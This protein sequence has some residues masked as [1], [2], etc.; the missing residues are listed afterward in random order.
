ME[1]ILTINENNFEPED[2]T[3]RNVVRLVIFNETKDKILFFGNNLVGGGVEEG[4]TDE[5]AIHREA[6][7]EVG[8]TVKIVKPIGEAVAYRDF[9]K[10]KYIVHGYICEQVGR[11]QERTTSDPEEQKEEIWPFSVSEA[12][13]KLE[14]EIDKLQTDRLKSKEKDDTFQLRIHNRVISLNLLKRV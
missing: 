5:E 4:E 1:R 10:K 3:I 11:L 7:E 12:I 6:M 9:L 8:A 13:Q 2:Y 14:R